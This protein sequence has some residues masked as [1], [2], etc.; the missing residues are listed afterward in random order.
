MGYS[1]LVASKERK[2]SKEDFDTAIIKLSEFN[3]KG[4]AGLPVCDIFFSKPNYIKVSG[5][6][7]ISGQYAE[8][9][10]LNLVINLIDLGYTPTV[11]SR[12]FEYGNEEDFKWLN[13]L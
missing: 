8:G 9:F 3:R 4:L 13:S 10:V 11:L 1:F 7:G 5:A 2:I 12:D 6:F